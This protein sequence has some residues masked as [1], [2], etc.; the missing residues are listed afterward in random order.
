MK[1]Y[2]SIHQLGE[3]FTTLSGDEYEGVTINDYV[4]SDKVDFSE[5]G[6]VEVYG[7]YIVAF[8]HDSATI[9]R[10]LKVY[11]DVRRDENYDYAYSIATNVSSKADY[12]LAIIM[13]VGMFVEE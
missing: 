8:V 1:L 13:Q 6:D 2:V 12:E 9:N 5:D 3:T 4:N 11:K 7:S 10:I